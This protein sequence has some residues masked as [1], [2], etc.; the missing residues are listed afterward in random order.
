MN[1][2]CCEPSTRSVVNQFFCVANSQKCKKVNM[3]P[4]KVNNSQRK[5]SST[6]WCVVL[7]TYIFTNTLYPSCKINSFSKHCC[8]QA[9]EIV[10]TLSPVML[11]LVLTLSANNIGSYRPFFSFL[12]SVNYAMW[13]SIA[14]YPCVIKISQISST[15]FIRSFIYTFYIEC[16]CK[17]LDVCLS[18]FLSGNIFIAVPQQVN[19]RGSMLKYAIIL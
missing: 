13:M 10:L 5:L 9:R 2:L 6:R 14:M 16:K 19:S 18:S 1:H 17:S 12:K 8:W 15:S 4:S 3:R 7:L 11:G